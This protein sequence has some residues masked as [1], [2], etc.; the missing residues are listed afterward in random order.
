M[1]Q[2]VEDDSMEDNN[3]EPILSRDDMDLRSAGSHCINSAKGLWDIL[4]V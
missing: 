2:Y 4:S 1:D 3:I